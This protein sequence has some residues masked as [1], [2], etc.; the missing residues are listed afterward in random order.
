MLTLSLVLIVLITMVGGALLAVGRFRVDDESSGGAVSVVVAPCVLALYLA[1]AAMGVVI[2]WENF[3]GAGDGVIAEVGAAESLY[4][5]TAAFPEGEAEA[6]RGQLR[7][8]MG[9]VAE[10]DW[11][12]MRDSGELSSAS[13]E[14]LADLAAS[15]R[16]LSVS[17]SGD[18]LD[19]LTARQELAELS[20]ARIKRADAAGEGVPPVLNAI[21]ALSAVAVAVLPFAMIRRGSSVAYFWAAANL[22]FVFSTILLLFYLGNPYNGA[23]AHDA[24]A[25]QDSLAGFDRTDAVLNPQ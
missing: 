17:D 10:K 20:D 16:E 24:G 23:L 4:W 15:V 12:L 11:P 21:A 3:T 6:V 18:G 22:V 19:R 5:S 2:G 1:S 8:Y 9:A 13:E 7:T 14:A 25:I